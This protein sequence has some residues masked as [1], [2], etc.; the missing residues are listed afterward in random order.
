MRETVP[1]WL[2]SVVVDVTPV[3]REHVPT[4]LSLAN[5]VAGP[6]AVT[7]KPLTFVDR[8]EADC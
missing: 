8:D 7:P 5:V 2:V 3:S 4:M 1:R 6:G